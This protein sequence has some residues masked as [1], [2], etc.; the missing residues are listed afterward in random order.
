MPQS[1]P[2]SNQFSATKKVEPKME[3]EISIE[4]IPF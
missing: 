3:E 4:D 2:S 1:T